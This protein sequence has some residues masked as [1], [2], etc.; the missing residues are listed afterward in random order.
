MLVQAL[1]RQQAQAA[2]AATQ[3]HQQPDLQPSSLALDQ[4]AALAAIVCV[5]PIV[6]LNKIYSR[7]PL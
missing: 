3:A 2:R 5:F 1:T 7:W 6:I 4:Q